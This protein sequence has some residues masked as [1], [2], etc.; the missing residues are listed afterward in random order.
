MQELLGE[1]RKAN[2]ILDTSGDDGGRKAAALDGQAEIAQ[3]LS[4][5]DEKRELKATKDASKAKFEAQVEA[6]TKLMA[7][8][9]KVSKAGLV[10]GIQPAPKTGP[11]LKSVNGM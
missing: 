9:R 10:G 3:K 5:E 1:I 8:N 11:A 6:L 4:D 7:D 2:A